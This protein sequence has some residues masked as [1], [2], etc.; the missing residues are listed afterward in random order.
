M[1]SYDPGDLALVSPG[2]NPG[3]QSAKR[4]QNVGIDVSRS[5]ELLLKRI[6]RMDPDELLELVESLFK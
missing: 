5:I 2:I 1:I 6:L 3:D 4:F